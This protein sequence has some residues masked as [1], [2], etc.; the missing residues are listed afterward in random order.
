[1][2]GASY[3]HSPCYRLGPHPQIRNKQ[4]VLQS[5]Q[6]SKG[7]RNVVSA[8]ESN[9]GLDDTYLEHGLQLM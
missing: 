8:L 7:S 9:Q 1:M 6:Q 5:G 3:T 2:M 4:Q